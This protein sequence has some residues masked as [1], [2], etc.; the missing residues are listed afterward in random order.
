ML[1]DRLDTRI[2]EA[3]KSQVDAERTVADTASPSWRQRCEVAHVAALSDDARRVF[4]THIAECRGK[5]VAAELEQ[6]ASSMRTSAIF[7]LARKLS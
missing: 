5:A 6:S 2:A 1:P 4:L 7:S 3:I